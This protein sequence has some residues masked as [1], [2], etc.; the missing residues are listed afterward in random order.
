[1]LGCLLGQPFFY[2]SK[3]YRYEKTLDNVFAGGLG[4]MAYDHFTGN[5]EEAEGEEQNQEQQAQPQL[6]QQTQPTQQKPVK[7]PVQKVAQQPIQKQA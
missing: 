4:Q 3:K 2:F 6:A 5:G 7:K 1:M